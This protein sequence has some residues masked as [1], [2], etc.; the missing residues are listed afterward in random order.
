M[1]GR[2]KDLKRHHNC[3]EVDTRNDD[4]GVLTIYFQNITDDI[5]VNCT[6]EFEVR[7]S[8]K[9]NKYAKFISIVERNQAIFNTEDR[10]NWYLWGEDAEQDFIDKIVPQI[11]LDIQKN[12]AKETHPW[13][14][15]LFDYTNQRYADLKT[16]NTPFFT[17][18]KYQYNGRP[19]DPTYTVTFNKKDYDNYLKRH[20]DCDIY[21]WVNWTQ[22]AYRQQKLQQ[23]KGIWRA[24]FSHM[25]E[26]IQANEVALH[27]YRHRVDDDRNARDSF[28]F[29]LNDTKVFERL[30]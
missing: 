18:G 11:H 10:E 3:G 12:P 17:A 13:E 6:V 28:L 8:A 25:I 26:K 30:L 1:E 22:V 14:I 27:P 23:V 7:T 21:F 24:H 19:Y 4:L 15:D 20:P 2:L 9:G 5:Q 16:Q 29:F